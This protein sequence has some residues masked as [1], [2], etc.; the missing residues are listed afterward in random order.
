MILDEASGSSMDWVKGVLGTKYAFGM[1]LRPPQGTNQGFITSTA[2]IKPTAMETW[3]G[4]KVVA[5]KAKS[6]LVVIG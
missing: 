1:E 2:N 3:E 5:S 4:I 6:S